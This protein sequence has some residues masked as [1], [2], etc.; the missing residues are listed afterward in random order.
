MSNMDIH[1]QS[2]INN[3]MQKCAFDMP[4]IQSLQD[5][6]CVYTDD[7]GIKNMIAY[8]R[9][10]GID[11]YGP[12][13]NISSSLVSL[14]RHVFNSLNE[15]V[16][17]YVVP[18]SYICKIKGLGFT[19]LLPLVTARM[20]L[21][22]LKTYKVKCIAY[23]RIKDSCDDLNICLTEL[24]LSGE[25]D[26][27]IP[28][29]KPLADICKTFKGKLIVWSKDDTH[30]QELYDDGISEASARFRGAEWFTDAQ[31]DVRLIGAGGLGSN[32]AVSLCRVLGR[33]DLFVYDD[34]VVEHKNLAGQNFGISDIGHTKSSVVVDQCYNFNMEGNFIDEQ[35]RFSE[36]SVVDRVVIEGLDNMATRSLVFSKW[37]AGEVIPN[38]SISVEYAIEVN[39]SRLLIDARLSA[40][41]WQI[42]CL[43][44]DN[45]KAQEEYEN[46]W[47]FTDE[48]ADSDVCSYKQTAYAAQ[49]CASYVTNLYINFC[50]NLSKAEDD[51]TRRYLPFMTEYD[52][53]QMILRFKEIV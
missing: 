37:Q 27:N 5:D 36:H 26:I 45:K 24:V 33:G 7:T 19:V 4:I 53:S 31:R 38:D 23:K 13:S 2:T 43:T 10:K 32:I 3:I 52:A 22:M 1:F 25:S 28:E 29:L 6:T 50:A 34:D 49:M 30:V 47:L 17:F 14:F 8:F 46:K 11:Y 12:L 39:K 18:N 48:E 21:S 44:G 9:D 16:E 40:E 35:G 15:T 42:F 20:I 51:P 41:K